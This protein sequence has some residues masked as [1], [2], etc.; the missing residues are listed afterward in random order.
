MTED[1]FVVGVDAAGVVARKP[2]AAM[3][4]AEVISALEIANDMT[5]RLN[6]EAE[7]AAGSADAGAAR[8][9]DQ[10]ASEAARRHILLMGAVEK[11]IPEWPMTGMELSEALERYWPRGRS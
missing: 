6:A 7:K 4:A 11:M 5:S 9:A 3:T 8:F 10:V 1:G 2:V